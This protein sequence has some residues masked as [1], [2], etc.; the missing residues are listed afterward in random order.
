MK[1][2]DKG[3]IA[4]LYPGD[5]FQLNGKTYKVIQHDGNMSEVW[6]FVWSPRMGCL[7]MD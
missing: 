3:Y 4:N 6:D 1:P 5:K 7:F 2:Y